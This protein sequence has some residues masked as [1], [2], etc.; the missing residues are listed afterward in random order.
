MQRLRILLLLLLVSAGWSV[1]STIGYRAY[2]SSY[3]LL[4]AVPATYSNPSLVVTLHGAGEVGNGTYNGTLI[5]NSSTNQVALTLV[6]GALECVNNGVTWFG[7][8][9]VIVAAPQTPSSWSTSTLDNT[10]AALIAEFHVN[11]ARI[12]VTGLSLGGGGAWAYGRDHPS[13]IYSLT[14]IAAANFPG[15]GTLPQFLTYKVYYVSDGNDPTVPQCWN[16]GTTAIFTAQPFLT[17]WLY[18]ITG[19]CALDNHP[20]HP[21]YNTHASYPVLT[22][23]VGLYS[24]NWN[25]SAW[26][27]TAGASLP[28]GNLGTT[29]YPTGGHGGWNQ[30]YGTGPADFNT[31]FWTWSLGV[32]APHVTSGV[33]MPVDQ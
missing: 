7:D 33:L 2:A 32:V 26:A 8:N 17:A 20:D 18:E 10:V 11:T 24:S 25:G 13:R 31:A 9:N 14:P 22:G 23:V 15:S 21:I 5:Y 28:T 6:N 3:P 1:T 30:T 19:I 27:W 12:C 4:V 29:L 16:Y